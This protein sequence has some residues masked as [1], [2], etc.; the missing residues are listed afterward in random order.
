[1]AVPWIASG[2]DRVALLTGRQASTQAASAEFALVKLP[3]KVGSSKQSEGKSY[4]GF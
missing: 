3:G 4:R 1:M 2:T